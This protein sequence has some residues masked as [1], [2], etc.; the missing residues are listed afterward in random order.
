MN[1]NYSGSLTICGL[2]GTHVSGATAIPQKDAQTFINGVCKALKRLDKLR[3]GHDLLQE[4]DASGHHCKIFLASMKNSTEYNDNCAQADPDGTASEVA[5]SIVSFRPRHHNLPISGTKISK[6]QG[7]AS[8]RAKSQAEQ[9]YKRDLRAAGA[10]QKKDKAAPELDVVLRRAGNGDL[11]RGRALASLLTGV[12]TADLIS[13]AQGTR[14]ITDNE[15]YKLCFYFYDFLSPGPGID[16]CVRLSPA[17]KLDA[18]DGS[19]KPKANFMAVPPEIVLGHELIHAWRMMTGRRV[20]RQGW[21]EEAMTTGI[22]LFRP[23]KFT[24]N[25]LRSEGGYPCRPTYSNGIISSYF[26]NNMKMQTENQPGIPK[27]DTY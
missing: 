17:L 22:G 27:V 24:E 8:G 15:Y 1:H 13:M 3:T 10:L 2:E 7:M 21:E 4:I 5:C 20:V 14:K 12:S 6:K 25:R 18:P 11:T 9:D 16:T 19:Y 23:W 26:G